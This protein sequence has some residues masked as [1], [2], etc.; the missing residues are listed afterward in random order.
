[1]SNNNGSATRARIVEILASTA[2]GCLSELGYYPGMPGKLKILEGQNERWREENV[3]LYQD[4]QRLVEL[5]RNQNTTISLSQIPDLDKL[6][7]ITDLMGQVNKLI[8]DNVELRKVLA[9]YSKLQQDHAQL[10]E[11]YKAAYD[12][13]QR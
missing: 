6:Q 11:L 4:N 3:K 5:T 8:S 13:V 2:N 12:E 10:F 9:K 7:R 1:Q